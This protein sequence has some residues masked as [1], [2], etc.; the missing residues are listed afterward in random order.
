MP[1]LARRAAVP[2]SAVLW[3][4]VGSV[5]VAAPQPAAPRPVTVRFELNDAQ[6]K[7][8]VSRLLEATESGGRDGRIILNWGS[9][10]DRV[11]WAS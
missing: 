5:A 8:R 1:R 6:V 4:L 2:M 9:R 10:P 3:A 7:G 11:G